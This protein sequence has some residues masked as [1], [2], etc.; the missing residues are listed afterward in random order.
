[1]SARHID[2]SGRR[3]LAARWW[4]GVA[5]A[6]L[7]GCAQDV[8]LIDRVQPGALRKSTLQGEWFYARTVVDVPYHVG[9]TFVGETEELDRVRFEIREDQLIA[10]RSYDFVAGTD[11]DHAAARQPGQQVH[12]TPVGAWKISKHFDITRSYNAATGEQTNVLEE[13]A[14]DRP[15]YE[16]EWI[17]VDWAN[18]LLTSFLFTVDGV[19]TAP[20][21]A[22][23]THPADPDALTLAWRQGAGWAE[24]RDPV[25]MREVEHVA[26]LD[27][28]VKVAAKPVAWDFWDPDWGPERYPACWFFLNEDCKPAEIA[29]RTAFLRVDPAEDADYLPLAYPDNVVARDAAGKALH[30]VE[31]AEIVDDGDEE[32][33]VSLGLTQDPDGYQVRI[34]YFDRFGYF[35]TERYGYD[36]KHGEVD[37]ARQQQINRYAIWQRYRDDQGQPLP[38]GARTP[39]PIVY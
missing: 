14:Q 16:R 36:P 34:P 9:Y 37:S 7:I 15:W 25:A 30:V 27:F 39:K 32:A 28:V 24:T 35:R 20:A 3:R 23:M 18:N 2:G 38:Y 12:G 8:G 6:W 31:H 13:N 4:S 5:A 11:L 33:T 17:R 10:Y 19:D 29:V 26:Y 1:M 21:N 22:A